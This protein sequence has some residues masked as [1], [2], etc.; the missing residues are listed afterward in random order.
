[1]LLFP[2]LCRRRIEYFVDSDLC[3]SLAGRRMLKFELSGPQSIT[4]YIGDTVPVIGK[5]AF[6]SILVF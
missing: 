1:M 3:L 6:L 5:R 4:R 2:D